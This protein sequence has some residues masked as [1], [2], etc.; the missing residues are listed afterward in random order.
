MRFVFIY[1]SQTLCKKQEISRYVLYTKSATLYVT[2]FSWKCWSWHLYTKSTKL[3]GTWRFN[4]QKSRPFAKSKTICV[5]FLYTKILTLCVTQLFIEFLKLAEGGGIFICK[6]NALCVAFLYAKYNA[7]C[8]TFL[9]TKI[10]TLCF[11]FLYWK[12]NHFALCFYI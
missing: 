7:F 5:T 1:K 3:C 2:Q 4:I 10:L 6:K 12:K 9:Y 8:V 11:T